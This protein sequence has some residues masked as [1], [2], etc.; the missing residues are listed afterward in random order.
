VNLINALGKFFDGPIYERDFGENDSRPVIEW[1]ESRRLFYNKILVV[2]GTVTCI[3]MISCGLVSE[4]MVGVAIGIPDPPI[5]IPIG[6]IAYLF[7]ANICYTGGWIA[8]LLLAKFIKSGSTTV[9]G[10]RAFRLGVKFSILLTL[11]PA[12]LSW[13]SLL[14]DL[15]TGRREPPDY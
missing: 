7:I 4:P 6:I 12:V 1:W 13:A 8:E 14:F 15:V 9:F 11:F 10:V 3:L 5:F 2:A